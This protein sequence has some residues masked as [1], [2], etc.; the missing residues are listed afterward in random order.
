M[1]AMDSAGWSG[2]LLGPDGPWQAGCWAGD[3][4]AIRAMLV[5]HGGS[6]DGLYEEVQGA[7]TDFGRWARPDRKGIFNDFP[8]LFL[9]QK[10][11]QKN[12]ENVFDARKILRKFSKF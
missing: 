7:S 12:L 2:A 1:A 6:V 5:G 10:Q 8:K 3:E 11:F 4:A 9:V